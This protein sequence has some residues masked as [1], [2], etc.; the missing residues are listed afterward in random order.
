MS[1]NKLLRSSSLVLSLTL[2]KGLLHKMFTFILI[3]ISLKE[4]TKGNDHTTFDYFQFQWVIVF[5]SSFIL[6]KFGKV[7]KR[8]SILFIL[9]LY[10][11][12]T[13]TKVNFFQNTSFPFFLSI[14]NH[15]II[16]YFRN[17]SLQI[18]LVNL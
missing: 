4:G 5:C 11:T 14:K 13:S 6:L 17:D 7:I 3:S 15:H 1:I 18:G 16:S 10:T 2:Q 9:D 8:N 12:K